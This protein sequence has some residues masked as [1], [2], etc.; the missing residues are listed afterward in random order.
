MIHKCNKYGNF[1][2]INVY[3]VDKQKSDRKMWRKNMCTI[4]VNET[5]NDIPSTS[6]NGDMLWKAYEVCHGR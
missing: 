3:E 1:Y 5:A 2:K 6:T 4:Q